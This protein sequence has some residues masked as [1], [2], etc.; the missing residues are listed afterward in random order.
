MKKNNEFRLGWKVLIASM[1]GVMCGAAPLPFNTFGFFMGPLNAEFGWSFAQMG[2]GVTI[3]GIT[4]SLLAPAFGW[5]ADRYGVRPVALL[6][7]LAFGLAFAA[8]AFTPSAIIGYYGLWLVLGLVG[9]GS[10]PV[11]W[12]RA[13]NLWFFK[14]RGLALGLTL[15]G[16]S[17]AAVFLPRLTVALIDNFSW[18]LAY[19]GLALL[20]VGLALP[21]AFVF[22]REPREEE[23]PKEITGSESK[24]LNG[25]N[26]ERAFKDY[27]FWVI[28]LSIFAV[29][30]AYGGAHIHL[31]QILGQLGFERS[32]AALIMGSLGVAIFMGRLFTGYLFDRFYAPYVTLP[33][34]SLPALA[35]WLLVNG[36][37]S[38]AQAYIAV[39]LLG[40][41]A[42]AEMD[43][44]AYLAGRYFGMAHYGKIYGMLY[45]PFGIAAAISPAAYGWV[46]DSFGNYNLALQTAMLLFLF[47]AFILLTL[48]RYPDLSKEAVTSS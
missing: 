15:I 5:A 44:I 31:P 41:A 17:L 8:F 40:L 4:A 21:L 30:L 14:S 48:G 29:A 22:F 24:K 23:R 2:L 43:L 28:F 12:T 45:M 34:L 19:P 11:T 18:R 13:I 9:I 47:G 38:M 6:S 36:D 35:C 37:V 46:R 27:R 7:L 1:V 39:M 32:D 25:V 16:T 42:G 33:I 10:T 3:F 26:L 20:P